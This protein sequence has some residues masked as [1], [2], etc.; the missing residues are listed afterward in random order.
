MIVRSLCAAVLGV[1]ALGGA[2]R[3]EAP[4]T[5]Q[6][7]AKG[8]AGCQNMM[9]MH[10]AGASSLEAK[11][12]AMNAAQGPEKVDAIAAVVNTLVAQHRAMADAC[13]MMGGGTEHADETHGSEHSA[14]HE[15]PAAPSEPATP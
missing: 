1:A 15:T 9:R 5:P 14:P 8:M 11:T 2:A 6:P 7:T 3:A 4:A 10:E 13:P 12:A